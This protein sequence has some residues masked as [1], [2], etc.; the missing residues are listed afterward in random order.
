MTTAPRLS[1]VVP[2]YGVE[3][4][5]RPCLESVRDQALTDIE[6]ICVDDGSLD[7]SREVADEF[8]AADPRFRV[9][10]QENQGLG[11]ARNAGVAAASG[12]YLTFV[13]SDDLVTRTGF[14]RMVHS[15]ERSGSSFAA[16]NARRF[17]NSS[18]ARQS[19]THRVAFAEKRV[20][21]HVTELPALARDRMVWNKVYR[22]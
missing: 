19:W 11:P 22:R 6:V 5:I 9:L 14:A 15:L 13:D 4:Y 18:G 7:H 12:E 20:A 8:A 2:F 21:T 17:N 1:V 16:G 3:D 10:A